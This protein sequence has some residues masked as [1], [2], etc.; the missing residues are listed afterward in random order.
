MYTIFKSSKQLGMKNRPKFQSVF[1]E[2]FCDMF[3][4]STQEPLQSH[5]LMNHLNQFCELIQTI[6]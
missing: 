1:I 4:H 6:H 3:A 5:M 2:H